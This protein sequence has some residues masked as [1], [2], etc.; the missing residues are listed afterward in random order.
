MSF[1]KFWF[2]QLNFDLHAANI[3]NKS[4]LI[5]F[6][7]LHRMQTDRQYHPVNKTSTDFENTFPK[8]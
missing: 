4:V 6:L 3:L 7:V 5:R 8:R 1:F 2:I